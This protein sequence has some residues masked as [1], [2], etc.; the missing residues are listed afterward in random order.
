MEDFSNF[1]K[2][3]LYTCFAIIIFGIAYLFYSGM[4]FLEIFNI[5]KE[6]FIRF[7]NDPIGR[8]IL[9]IGSLGIPI[10]IINLFLR[11]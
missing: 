10:S 11:R 7:Y 9:F 3:I 4:S 5:I 8:F 2:G 6:P 1:L